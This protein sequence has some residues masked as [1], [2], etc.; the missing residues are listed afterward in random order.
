MAQNAALAAAELSGQSSAPAAPDASAQNA[1]LQVSVET[2]DGQSQTGTLAEL[3]PGQVTLQGPDGPLVFPLDQLRRLAPSSAP[4]PAAGEPRAWIELV[5]GTSICGHE[6]LAAQGKARVALLDGRSVEIPLQHVRSVRLQAADAEAQQEWSRILDK[7]LH[8]DVL[9]VRNEQALNYVAGVLHEVTADTV[10]FELEGETVP[11]G[12]RKV[13]GMVYYHAAEPQ[14]PAALGRLAESS[15][16]QWSVAEVSLERGALHFTTP[17]GVKLEMPLAALSWLDL[18]AGK[19]Q[20]LSDLEPVA[21]AWTP[22][23]GAA[24]EIPAL[25][26]F[27]APRRDSNLAGRPLQL[28]G[29]QYRKGL[30]LHSRTEMVFRLPGEFRYFEAVAGIDDA[31]RPQGNVRLVIHGDGQTLWEGQLAGRD[32]PQLIRL[33][34]AGVRRL[35]ILVDFGADLDVADHLDLCEARVIK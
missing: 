3:G 14:L 34:I 16:S 35:G 21:V 27:F 33:E 15:G 25:D 32:E 20:Y 8:S 31:V 28:A 22:F 4:R 6:Y 1:A 29:T 13:F 24:G 10:S 12:R 11:V 2:L 18:S 26:R 30:C 9:V 17:A 19:I 23:F 7:Q 5:D